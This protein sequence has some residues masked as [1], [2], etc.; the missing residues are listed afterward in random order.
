MEFSLLW[1][2]RSFRLVLHAEGGVCC[3]KAEERLIADKYPGEPAGQEGRAGC[4]PLLKE[5]TQPALQSVVLGKHRYGDLLAH[6][7]L[8]GIGDIACLGNVGVVI[9]R[10]VKTVADLGE[11]VSALDAVA[12]VGSAGG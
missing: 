4:V 1:N 7:N 12:L 8:V 3:G 5:G 10:A 2:E 11:I 6:L 9:G